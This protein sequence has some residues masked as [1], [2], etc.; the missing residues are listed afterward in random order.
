MIN[1]DCHLAGRPGWKG[2]TR[3]AI[4]LAALEVIDARGLALF[5]LRGVAQHLHVRAASLYNHFEDRAELFR[6]VVSVLYDT[7]EFE[8]EAAD[9]WRTRTVRHSLALRRAM[10]AHPRAVPLVPLHLSRDRCR[11]DFRRTL[12]DAPIAANRE[13][14]IE[15][16]EMV[17]IGSTLLAAAVLEAEQRRL[18]KG[19]I[20]RV[21]V[22]REAA[23][24]A[25]LELALDAIGATGEIR[26]Q[27]RPA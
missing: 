21:D 17:T 10:L 9:D 6:D 20:H 7:L 27:G 26:H 11:K 8:P 25:A 24:V 1:G 16:I 4:A 12:A 19:P 14:A 3:D 13:V 23:F 22:N 15:M 2:L 18:D 5:G